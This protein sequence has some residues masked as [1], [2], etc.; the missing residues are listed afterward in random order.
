MSIEGR[1]KLIERAYQRAMNIRDSEPG[2]DNVA[3]SRYSRAYRK[4]YRFGDIDALKP[5]TRRYLRAL[6]RAT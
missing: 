6:R 3:E 5:E 4:A 1:R 2:F